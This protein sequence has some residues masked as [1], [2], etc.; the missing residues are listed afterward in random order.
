MERPEV[1]INVAS[2]LDGVIASSEGALILST[3][4]DW[5]RVHELRNSV[6][7]ILVGINTIEKDDPLLT[8]RYVTPKKPHPLRVI[9]DSTCKIPL[10]SKILTNLE[11]YPTLIVTAGNSSEEKI[12]QLEEVGAKVLKISKSQQHGYLDLTEILHKLKQGFKVN[13]LLVEGGSK[14][15][16][17]FLKLK[18]VDRLHI[19]Y[20]TLLA[21]TINAKPLYEE[22]VVVNVAD[23]LNFKL[24]KID[25]LEEGFIVTLKPK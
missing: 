13:K 25:Q 21:G 5:I 15:I 4:E 8:I 23:T 24:E 9:L 20:A 22:E 17:Q 7:A 10:T 6:D 11:N 16:T 2:S 12:K 19:F 14:I 18:L 1:I 3:K